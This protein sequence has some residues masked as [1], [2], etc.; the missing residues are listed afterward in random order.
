MQEFSLT[1][2]V[3][4][5]KRRLVSKKGHR[6]LYGS[7][8]RL[9]ET[10]QKVSPLP[11]ETIQAIDAC[12]N[13]LIR[14][15][16]IYQCYPLWAIRCN[17]C[18]SRLIEFLP[19]SN[20]YRRLIGEQQDSFADR[21]IWSFVLFPTF[22][23]YCE[24]LSMR[25]E[26]ACKVATLCFEYSDAGRRPH[27][28]SHE[29]VFHSLF[30]SGYTLAERYIDSTNNYKA[31]EEWFKVLNPFHLEQ[32]LEMIEDCNR[33]DDPVYRMIEDTLLKQLDLLGKWLK[34]DAS[35]FIGFW[36]SKGVI[37]LLE[38]VEDDIFFSVLKALAKENHNVEARSII[39]YYTND[40]EIHIREYAKQ[41]LD[42]VKPE[43]Y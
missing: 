11:Q 3:N 16:S 12:V 20:G 17:L 15:A 8:D 38:L 34:G 31:F 5:L 39:E 28:M 23:G 42:N 14:E 25:P 10:L 1:D 35:S 21:F 27:I 22:E 37:D 26:R 4:T 33:E 24:G 40:D 6:F 13:S 32:L 36:K 43:C 9:V 29:E 19:N 2:R 30:K 41:L 7:F 18:A